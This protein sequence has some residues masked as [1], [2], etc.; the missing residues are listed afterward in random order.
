MLVVVPTITN[1]T[2][3]NTTTITTLLQQLQL[4]VFGISSG[5]SSRSGSKYG[6]S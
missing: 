3:A 5:C 1:G 2:I 4:G 6:G